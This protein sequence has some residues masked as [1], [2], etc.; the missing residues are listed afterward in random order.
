V[1]VYVAT[2]PDIEGFGTFLQVQAPLLRDA[3]VWTL[4]IVFARPLDRAYAAYQAVIHEELASPLHSAT[5][6]ELKWYFEHRRGAARETVHATT[7]QTLDLA[8]QVFGA[9][10]FTAMYH[11][12]LRHGNAVFDGP[13]SAATAEALASGR[14]RVEPIVLPSSYRHLAPLVAETPAR[15]ESIGE[16]LSRGNGRGNKAPHVLNAHPQ[17]PG[18]QAPLSIREQQERDWRRLVDAH[19]AQKAQEFR[20]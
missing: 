20:Q 3:K 19:N 6:S 12:W 8:A 11:R 10:R 16:G 15:P 9:P 14:G 7:R 1:L 17:P 4:R 18:D 2:A 5:I 13:S